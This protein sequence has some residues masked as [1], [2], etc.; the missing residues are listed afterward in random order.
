MNHEQI[1]P[2]FSPPKAPAGVPE[3]AFLQ[4]T[5][6]GYLDRLI[7]WYV[8]NRQISDG[9]FGGGLSDDTDFLNWWPGLA[10]MGSD[11]DKLKASIERGLEATFNNGMW[12]NGL[13]RAQ[14]DELHS[15]EDGLN[16]LGQ[17]MQLDFGNPKQL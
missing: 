12:E 7:N 5:D 9:E 13:A 10:F 14:Y 15:Y 3:W 2:P 4:T 11:P 17:T 8:D 16:T 6:L 1:K